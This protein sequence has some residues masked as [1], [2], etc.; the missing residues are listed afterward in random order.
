VILRLVLLVVLTL[1]AVGVAV[2]LQ[3]RRPEAPSAPSYRAPTQLDRADFS[4]PETPILVVVFS[5]RTCDSCAGVWELVGSLDRPDTVVERIDVEADAERHKRYRIDG[6]P[7]T[8]VVDP[9]GVVQHS[10]FGPI[11]AEEFRLALPH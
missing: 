1:M 9:R 3:R 8:L 10:F 4:E 5:S 7:T 6:V 2:V 11:P